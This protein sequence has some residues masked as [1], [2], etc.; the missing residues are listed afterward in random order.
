MSESFS[1]ILPAG[2]FGDAEAMRILDGSNVALVVT[3]PSLP[4]NPIVYVN[5]AFETVTG[6]PPAA[7]LGRNCR[8]LQGPMTDPEDI[9]RLRAAIAA[10]TE[11]SVD[12]LNYRADGS[13]YVNR[14]LLTPIFDDAGRLRHFLGVQK[15]L[16]REERGLSVS[17][18]ARM[19][20][21]LQHRVKNHLALI[22]S[23]IRL[24]AREAADKRPFEKLGQRVGSLQSLY[25]ELSDPAGQDRSADR[26]ALSPFLDRIAR[27]VQQ[28]DGRD[29]LEIGIVADGIAVSMSTGAKLGLVVTEVLTNALKHA[30]P[31]RETGRITITATGASDLRLTIADD[32]AG[33]AEGAVWP[34]STS[35]GGRV[36][37]SLLQELDARFD[38]ASG[39]TGTAIT[40]DLPGAVLAPQD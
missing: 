29:G 24:E 39:P 9:A 10:E 14:L 40:F 34:A 15:P 8:F 38:L 30:F 20:R 6:Y 17:F 13:T 7:A 32:G 27:A 4:D 36:I 5:R 33:M 25:A 11:T 28:V 12:I 3:D 19:V 22:G 23:L 21:E 18:G 1:S 31:D 37:T 16:T 2:G 35:V 26:I